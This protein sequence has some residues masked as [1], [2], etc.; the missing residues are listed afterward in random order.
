MPIN[1]IVCGAAGRMGKLL[2]S[3]VQ[4]HPETRLVGAIEALGHSA[5][6]K[7]AG[8]VAGIG[9][10][11]VKVTDDYGAVAAPD[12]VAL[13]FTV[14]EAALDHLRT[15]VAR[16]AAIVIG[17]TG[18][19]AEQRA[20]AEKIAPKTRSLIAPNMS[21]GVNVLLKVVADVARILQDGFDPEIVEIHHRFKVDAPSGT[22]LALGRAVATAQGKDFDRQATL[23]RQGI[24]GQRTNDEIGIMA[25]RGG[26][27]VGDHTVIFA[28]F[29]E[30]LEL[31][32]RAQSRECL[33]RG[34][35]R[36]ALWL[37]HQPP[38]LYSMKDVLGL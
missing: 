7:D 14:A 27:I 9:A 28:G 13:D 26:D 23:A 25:L 20:E 35:L 1:V 33:A 8:E 34:A 15:A 3:L 21:V 24:T 18:F 2:V 10:I 4:D 11:G 19:S 16:G 38:G 32:H 22:A 30:R 5:V 29:G 12:T 36:A 6:G 37:P 31:T 17:T